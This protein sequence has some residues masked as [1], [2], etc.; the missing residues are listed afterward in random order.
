MPAPGSAFA[1]HEFKPRE[2]SREEWARYHTYRRIRHQEV[3]PEDP[4]APDEQIEKSMKRE[5]P[6]NLNRQYVVAADDRIVS[7]Y[8]AG[9]VKPDAPGFDTN[10]Q[11]LWAHGGVV[12]DYRRRGIGTMWLRRTLDLMEEWDRSLLTVWWV[13]EDDG[14]AFLRRVGAGEKSRMAE[15][16]L[17]FRRIDWEM[18]GR[19]IREG[20]EKAPDVELELFE[21][22]LPDE[23]LEEYAPILSELLMTM[24]FDDLDHGDIVVTP[25]TLREGQA[26]RDDVGVEIHTLVAR[27]SDGRLAGMTDVSRNPARPGYIDQRFTGVH[28]DARGRGLGKLLKASMLDFLSKR[29][30]DIQWVVTGNAGS[31]APMLAINTKL[32]FREHRPASVYQI[33]REEIEKFLAGLEAGRLA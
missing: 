33:T 8:G 26:R 19:W 22:R 4:L 28:P 13:E 6:F 9:A 7:F 25:E 14:H 12:A 11:Y 30:D 17:D 15:N 27:L 32:G 23:F 10:K 16:R 24:P 21:N 31:N 5:D 18:I 2:A 3:R 1:P 20:R 29:Y